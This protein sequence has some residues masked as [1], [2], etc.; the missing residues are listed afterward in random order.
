MRSRLRKKM[1]KRASA[2]LELLKFT[3]DISDAIN[4]A[5]F[6]FREVAEAF[7]KVQVAA[8]KVPI[9]ISYQR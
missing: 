8:D 7:K 2:R 6:S 3:K 1:Q 5:A 4:N 9:H